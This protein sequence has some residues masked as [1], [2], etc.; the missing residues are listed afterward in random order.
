MALSFVFVALVSIIQSAAESTAAA[1][2][3]D[4]VSLHTT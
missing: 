2:D 4:S 1:I 3:V